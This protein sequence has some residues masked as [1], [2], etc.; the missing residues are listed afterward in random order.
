MIFGL[1]G[2]LFQTFWRVSSAG[3]FACACC[4]VKHSPSLG[5]E[6]TYVQIHNAHSE[7]CGYPYP[8][9]RAEENE[10]KRALP[11]RVLRSWSGEKEKGMVASGINS[12]HGHVCAG[13]LWSC[14]FCRK[15]DFNLAV[16]QIPLV[17]SLKT[18]VID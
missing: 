1:P 2:H 12:I 9:F 14:S 5:R 13:E 6:M 15:L 16:G 18:F 11:R 3:R 10:K 8:F 4:A 17:S 7:I